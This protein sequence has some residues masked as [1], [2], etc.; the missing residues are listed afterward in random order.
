MGRP[1]FVLREPQ[2]PCFECPSKF[3][4]SVRARACLS[5]SSIYT[6]NGVA[7]CPLV[8]FLDVFFWNIE[9]GAL[10]FIIL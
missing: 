8:F 4:A 9:H 3:R 1:F 5:V 6:I 10:I 7:Y 2:Q